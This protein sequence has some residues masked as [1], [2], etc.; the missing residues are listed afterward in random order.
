[1]SRIVTREQYFESALA[2]LAELGFTG[3]NIRLMC[4][5]LGVTAGSFYHHFG[6]WQGFVDALLAYWENRQVMILRDVEFGVGPPEVDIES[7]RQLTLGLRHEA[8]AAIRAWGANDESVRVVRD[9][10]DEARWK[11]VYKAVLRVVGDRSVATVVTSLGMSMLV[12]YQQVAADDGYVPLE[13]LLDEYV[14][15]IY[16]HAEASF[17]RN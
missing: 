7:L 14:Q 6:S 2:A 3:L 8:E 12:G 1:M 4:T 5:R 10:V 11:T 15:I 16:S 13:R 17:Q 9:R